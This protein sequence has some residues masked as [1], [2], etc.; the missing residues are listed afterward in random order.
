MSQHQD[1]IKALIS[2]TARLAEITRT[3]ITLTYTDKS[4]GKEILGAGT[5]NAEKYQNDIDVTVTAE[6]FK[7]SHE[8]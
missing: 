1:R 5:N 7:L 3:K 8:H 6:P 2:E 4:Y